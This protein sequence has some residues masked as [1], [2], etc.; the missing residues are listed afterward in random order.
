[1]YRINAEGRRP[2]GMYLAWSRRSRYYPTYNLIE[3]GFP[4]E[5][6]SEIICF[7]FEKKKESGFWY[8]FLFILLRSLVSLFLFRE[9]MVRSM[10]N[11]E[12]S[13]CEMWITQDKF[14]RNA[15]SSTHG[16]NITFSNCTLHI[17]NFQNYVFRTKFA[18]IN[19]IVMFVKMWC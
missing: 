9:N 1:M 11:D 4:R 15:A 12:E 8:A 2:R 18:R 10:D 16:W 14:S 19:C 7:Y 13:H 3:G 17:D 6:L 5:L